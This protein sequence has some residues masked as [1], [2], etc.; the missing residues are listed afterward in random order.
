MSNN[1]IETDQLTK[2]F[3]EITAVQ[4][5]DLRVKTGEIYGFL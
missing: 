2:R 4:S 3:G 1:A 5:V